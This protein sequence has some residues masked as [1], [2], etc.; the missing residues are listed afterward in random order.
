MWHPC[1]MQNLSNHTWQP[2]NPTEKACQPPRLH[3][4][5]AGFT[6]PK[7]HS[8]LWH[9]CKGQGSCQ[10]KALQAVSMKCYSGTLSPWPDKFYFNLVSLKKFEVFL[11]TLREI[12]FFPFV[13]KAE[14]V[15]SRGRV[16]SSLGGVSDTK[17][18]TLVLSTRLPDSCLLLPF[19]SG[20]RTGRTTGRDPICATTCLEGTALTVQR[21][22]GFLPM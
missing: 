19:E 13:N 1:A 10:Y 22:P 2:S 3:D 4:R 5:W 17:L 15:W 8:S 16:C 7:S 6:F 20:V 9:D 21:L 18:Q 11:S 12:P 14:L